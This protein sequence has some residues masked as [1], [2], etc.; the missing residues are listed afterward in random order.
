[1]IEHILWGKREVGEFP[2]PF[3][4]GERQRPLRITFH[5]S[6]LVVCLSP[7]DMEALGALREL[8]H[9]P[10]IEALQMEAGPF[11]RIAIEAASNELDHI[12]V[13]V[14]YGDGRTRY[15]G[16][17]FPQQW[18]DI[19]ARMAHA[20]NADHPSAK[21]MLNDLLVAQAHR[22]LDQ[23]LLVTASPWLLEYRAQ[24]FVR[25]ANP[26]TPTEAAQVVGLFLR[27]RGDY[28]YWAGEW[29]GRRS[30]DRGLFY[31]VLVRHRLPSMW[32]YFSACVHAEKPRGD[33]IL[34]LGQSILSRCVRAIQAR[35]AIGELFYIPQG[36]NSRDSMM[37]HFDYLTLVLAGAFDAQARV[38][39]RAYKI[40]KPRDEKYVSFRRA[41]FLASL[42]SHGAK[43]LYNLVSEQRFQDVTTL[44]YELRNTIHGAG[45]PTVGCQSAGHPEASFV[46]VL[47]AYEVTLWKAAERCGSPERWGLVRHNTVLFEPYTCVV[48]LIEEC[49]NLVDSVANVTDVEGLFP[50][51]YPIPRLSDKPPEDDVFCECV[52][53]R[54]AVLG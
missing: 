2:S 24:S 46:A 8:S 42:S 13:T 5:G 14:E 22:A 12:P 6:S 45:F 7:Q 4:R 3:L 9:V 17:P 11:P 36:N 27:S 19:A 28:T 54:L 38:A 35:D 21:A 32:R 25:E 34:H 43:D 23:D 29:G 52:R 15:A 10:E 39:Y 16:I 40:I 33:D 48:T 1:M 30:L 41:E 20:P 53:K 31:W 37:Y 50:A 26:R 49:L 51:G 44:L 47:P 18:S